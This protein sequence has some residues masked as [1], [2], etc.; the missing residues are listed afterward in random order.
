MSGPYMVVVWLLSRARRLGRQ[1]SGT[2]LVLVCPNHMSAVPALSP[3]GQHISMQVHLLT[4]DFL[5]KACFGRCQ[6]LLQRRD[7]A[8]GTLFWSQCG[9]NGD[10]I[11]AGS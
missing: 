4:V 7:D 5:Q 3:C 10:V 8:C 1:R 2:N 6:L 9:S 11:G